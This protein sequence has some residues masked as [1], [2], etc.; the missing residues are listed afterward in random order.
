MSEKQLVHEIALK[1]AGLAVAH[2]A[3]EIRPR[4]EEYSTAQLE[5]L[6]DFYREAVEYCGKNPGWLEGLFAP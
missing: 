3:S 2:G 5:A 1:Y 6:L 4:I